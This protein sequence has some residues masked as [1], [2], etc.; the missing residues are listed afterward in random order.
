MNFVLKKDDK[1]IEFFKLLMEKQDILEEKDINYGKQYKFEFFVVNEYKNKFMFQGD[2][3]VIY[4]IQK[5]YKKFLEGKELDLDFDYYVGLDEA[6]KG[7]KVGPIVLALVKLSKQAVINLSSSGIMDSKNLSKSR[8]FDFY[9]L[10]KKEAD[11][12]YV[13]YIY[14]IEVDNL[15]VNYVLFEKYKMLLDFLD[16]DKK[17]RVILDDFGV[18]KFSDILNRKRVEYYHKAEQFV[19]VAAASIVARANYL[20]WLYKRNI[21][22]TLLDEIKLKYIKRKYLK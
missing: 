15:N 5:E 3:K 9:D 17:T 12:I 2:K 4:E 8:I 18:K 19:E 21:D 20:D 10:I 16:I 1:T 22:S 6:G 13:S 14:P 11:K 7:E